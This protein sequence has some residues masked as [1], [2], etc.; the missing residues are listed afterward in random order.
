MAGLTGRPLAPFSYRDKGMMATIGRRAAI[1]QLRN[2]LVLRGT[3]EW[4]AGFGPFGCGD[5]GAIWRGSLRDG[6]PHRVRPVCGVTLTSWGRKATMQLTASVSSID[7]HQTLTDRF[8]AVPSLTES[9]ASC[10]SG[11]DQTV[12]SMPD[13]SPTKWPPAHTTWFFESFLLVPSLLDYDVFHPD[14]ASFL[15]P[16][17][18]APV[19]ATPAYQRCLGVSGLGDLLGDLPRVAESQ[20]GTCVRAGRSNARLR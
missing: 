20:V 7:Q 6:E 10:L 18:R 11:K 5:A 2:G 3:L 17:M 14:Y 8:L 9:L 1:A 16:T 4:I 12:K 15:I 19:P 13:A